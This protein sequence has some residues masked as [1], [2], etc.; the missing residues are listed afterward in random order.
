MFDE[1]D[2]VINFDGLSLGELF[3]EADK[4]GRKYQSQ[5]EIEDYMACLDGATEALEDTIAD[6]GLDD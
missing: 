5:E 3:A 1:F 6:L 2:L 4:I